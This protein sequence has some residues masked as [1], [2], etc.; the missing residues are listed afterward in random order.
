MSEN[1][2][3]L[4]D[5]NL[6]HINQEAFVY[7]LVMYSIQVPS[8]LSQRAEI[9]RLP[10]TVSPGHSPS[11]EVFIFVTVHIFIQNK[12]LHRAVKETTGKECAGYDGCQGCLSAVTPL[13]CRL[14]HQWCRK[15]CM[16]KEDSG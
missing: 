16:W 15:P 9:K 4:S 6:I 10:V 3:S 5:Y 13:H 2:H 7:V 1:Y 8:K 14:G 11:S 12:T